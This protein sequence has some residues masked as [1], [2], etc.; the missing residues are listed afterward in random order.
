MMGGCADGAEAS[1][2]GLA[3]VRVSIAKELGEQDRDLL[4]LP[5][6]SHV[7]QRGNA[8]LV[9]GQRGNPEVPARRSCQSNDRGQQVNGA[10]GCSGYQ[11]P[12][13]AGFRYSCQRFG[14]KIGLRVVEPLPTGNA[15]FVDT[16]GREDVIE[17][18]LGSEVQRGIEAHGERGK[19]RG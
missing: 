12:C 17:R 9:G 3:G 11:V 8:A 13:L 18:A 1:Q 5:L 2:R 7:C 6:V 15:V 10:V 14:G 19:V 4:Q 16:L